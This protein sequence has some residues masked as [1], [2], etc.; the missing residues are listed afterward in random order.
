MLLVR[1]DKCGVE[2]RIGN[3][4]YSNKELHLFTYHTVSYDNIAATDIDLCNACYDRYAC[5]QRKKDIEF[6]QT[7]HNWLEKEVE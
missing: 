4:L 2:T 3:C 7:V 1:C 5:L 6:Y